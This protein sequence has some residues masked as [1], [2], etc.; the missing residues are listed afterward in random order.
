M[1][2]Y[3]FGFCKKPGIFISFTAT[4]LSGFFGL[5]PPNA[6]CATGDVPAPAFMPENPTDGDGETE[7]DGAAAGREVSSSVFG[8][9]RGPI[10]AQSSSEA[11]SSR[12]SRPLSFHFIEK[13]TS[14]SSKSSFA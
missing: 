13:G 7:G 2:G 9:V 3:F 4:E 8:A 1:A 10:Q 11:A 6:G 12:Q 5:F 14:Y